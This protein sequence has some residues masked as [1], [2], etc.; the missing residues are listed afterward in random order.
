[1]SRTNHILKS[2][3]WAKKSTITTLLS[4]SVLIPLLF[5]LKIQSAAIAPGILKIESNRKVIAHYQNS[6]VE[7]IFISEGE[8][9]Y[10]GQLLIQ[11][12]NTIEQSKY[13]QI[14]NEFL[15][16]YALYSRLLSELDRHIKVKIPENFD[17]ITLLEKHIEQQNRIF[18]KRKE[19]INGV[20]TIINERIRKANE[21]IVS[22]ELKEH[23]DNKILRTI[24]QQIS[25]QSPLVKKGLA[26]REKILDYMIDRSKIESSIGN[27]K[28]KVRSA[29]I[30]IKQLEQELKN[31]D[32]DFFSV[33]SEEITQ[34]ENRLFQLKER[35]FQAK[36]DLERT[37]IFSP[38]D[39]NVVGLSIFTKGGVISAHSTLM[40][41]VPADRKYIVEALLDPKDIDIINLGDD[42]SI[43]LSA[44]NFRSIRPLTGNIAVVSADRVS[45]PN[46]G[47]SAYSLRVSLNEP[48]Q[49]IK[50]H[51]GMQA[52]VMILKENRTIIN[53]LTT[54]ILKVFSKSFKESD[55]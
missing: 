6:L 29:H 28:S 27:T 34:T 44:Y 53:Y 11:A 22:L 13:E 7:E 52:E 23:T 4:A 15:S 3:S 1:M 42:V 14:R 18:I 51:P 47:V 16:N 48:T 25:M 21:E 46:T 30:E 24:K 36:V 33:I 2:K 45:E 35:L 50:L 8:T 12:D 19:K 37:K 54:P 26:S 10:K 43:R 17:S 5:I 38:V 40:E 32:I 20:K 31:T 49:N 39:G 55:L 9:V 41:I